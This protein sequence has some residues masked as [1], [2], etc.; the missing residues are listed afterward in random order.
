MSEQPQ[1]RVA[2]TPAPESNRTRAGVVDLLALLGVLVLAGGVT[3]LADQTGHLSSRLAFAG[4]TGLVL[5]AGCV[6]AWRR[7]RRPEPRRW[8]S[9]QAVYRGHRVMMVSAWGV[10]GQPAPEIPPPP[11]DE[12]QS[13]LDRPCSTAHSQ[14]RPGQRVSARCHR[15]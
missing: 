9:G 15:R 2:D 1:P 5:V 11:C 3:L 14:I 6:T 13:R 8:R 10:Q 7:L 12:A 4:G